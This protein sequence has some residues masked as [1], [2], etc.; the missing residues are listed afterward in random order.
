MAT[1]IFSFGFGGANTCG[2]KSRFCFIM[3]TVPGS[4][5]LPAGISPMIFNRFASAVSYVGKNS[6]CSTPSLAFHDR[7]YIFLPRMR[8]AVMVE[9]LSA[10]AILLRLKGINA[11][12]KRKLPGGTH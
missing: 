10:V 5:F 12:S 9:R 6:L 2:A 11:V 7:R 3:V 8:Q 1:A 4:S